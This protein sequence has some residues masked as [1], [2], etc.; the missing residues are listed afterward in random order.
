MLELPLKLLVNRANNPSVHCAR[1]K[2]PCELAYR[3]AFALRS[4]GQKLFYLALALLTR[5]TEERS[6][7][8]QHDEECSWLDKQEVHNHGQ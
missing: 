6:E 7:D 2:V 5:K 1:I 4:K 3:L 8:T